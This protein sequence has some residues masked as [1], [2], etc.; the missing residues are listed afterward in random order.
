VRRNS[1]G[2]RI[3]VAGSDHGEKVPADRRSELEE[4]IA[5]VRS[6]SGGEEIKA[7]R[8]VTQDLL[9]TLQRIG[10]SM[11]QAPETP[12]SADGDQEPGEEGDEDVI[13]GEF[14]ETP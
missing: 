14:R 11:Y 12:P 7:I 13:E 4:K 10:A 6:A 3:S 8:N 5:S 2:R 9:D 1:I